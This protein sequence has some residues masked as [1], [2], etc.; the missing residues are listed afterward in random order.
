M[1]KKQHKLIK[2][3]RGLFHS[4]FTIVE[5]ITAL[6]VVSILATISYAYFYGSQQ[7]AEDL[8]IQSDVKEIRKK[9]ASNYA[10]YVNGSNV[11][12]STSE[13]Y[14]KSLDLTSLSKRIGVSG[15]NSDSTV[16]E[17]NNNPNKN[18]IYMTPGNGSSATLWYWSNSKNGW[19][20]EDLTAYEEAP[21]SEVI[22]T[23]VY[24]TPTCLLA[25]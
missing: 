25:T 5:I 16:D 21:Y 9:I 10:F 22:D 4:G 13:L 12:L 2:K 7:K 6:V 19:I 8:S 17:C 20:R 14:L 1:L 23:T 15:L 11:E 18:K 3:R 24:E